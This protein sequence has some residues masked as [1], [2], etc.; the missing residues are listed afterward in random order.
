ML[1]PSKAYK[2]GS[3]PLINGSGLRGL[4]GLCWVEVPGCWTGE[5]LGLIGALRIRIGFWALLYYD[6]TKD[7]PKIV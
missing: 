4:P 7:H 5:G 1:V 3:K 2:P 6:Y